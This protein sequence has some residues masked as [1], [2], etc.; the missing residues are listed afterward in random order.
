[1][2]VLRSFGKAY[3]LAG[4]R[5]GFALA[6]A[7][8]ATSL[9]SALGP[10]PV[11]GPAI[12]IGVRALADSDWLEA[13]RARLGQ[14][15]ARLDLLLQ[16]AGW[17]IIGGKS[18]FRLAARA[19]ARAAFEQLLAAGILARPFADAPDRVRFGIPAFETAWERLATALRG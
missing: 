5:L 11:S 4:L 15:A 17:R 19:D 18:L 13:T 12:A 16:N 6:S 7:D 9:R 2:V 10:W 14:E 1:V 8:I 3:G